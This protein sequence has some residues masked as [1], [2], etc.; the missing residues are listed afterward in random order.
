M[1]IICRNCRWLGS[2][3]AIQ[4]ICCFIKQH[5]P[6]ILFLMETK[7]SSREL[8]H[9]INN[10]KFYGMLTVDFIGRKE[11]LALCWTRD[12]NLHIKSYSFNHISALI[13]LNH[14]A[15]IS[16]FVG[17]YG[18]PIMEERWRSW[19]L[20]DQICYPVLKTC[21]C[22]VVSLKLLIIMKSLEA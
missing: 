3:R 8:E 11:G 2:F 20:L 4:I 5:N 9:K 1:K 16:S 7:L 18:E 22:V 12:V 21:L 15:F 17:F 14:S 13:D 6:Q 19:K 10:W